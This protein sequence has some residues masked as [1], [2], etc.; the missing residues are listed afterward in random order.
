VY[1]QENLIQCDSQSKSLVSYLEQ[2]HKDKVGHINSLLVQLPICGRAYL[3]LQLEQKRGQKRYHSCE[4]NG[5]IHHHHSW[6][7]TNTHAWGA[8][9]ACNYH[10]L[11]DGCH[12]SCCSSESKIGNKSAKE[13]LSKSN[14]FFQTSC[15]CFTK[16]TGHCTW[17]CCSVAPDLNNARLYITGA[18]EYLE[19]GLSILDPW[20][21]IVNNFLL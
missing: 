20:G 10:Y 19:P 8:R 14:S 17:P 12:S 3:S 2:R 9:S 5:Y 18:S 21:F 4:D 16:R 13:I 6:R 15:P 1:H 11:H 7:S